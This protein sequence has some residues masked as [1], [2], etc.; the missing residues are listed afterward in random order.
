MVFLTSLYL[1]ISHLLT[2]QSPYEESLCKV[3]FPCKILYSRFTFDE[4]PV[5]TLTLMAICCIM[6]IG[7]IYNWTEYKRHDLLK[8]LYETQNINFSRTFFRYSVQIIVLRK[9]LTFLES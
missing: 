6:F 1:L 4:K 5:Y 7:T 3:Y 9:C 2:T 8:D